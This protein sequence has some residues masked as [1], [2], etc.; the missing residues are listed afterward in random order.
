MENV[1]T[2]LKRE[3]PKK[4]RDPSMFTLPGTIGDRMVSHA[5]LDRG[6]SISAVSYNV[7]QDLK[8]N[9]LQKTTICIQLAKYISPPGIIEV[10]VK[11]V[12]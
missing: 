1:S 2:L 10:L 11:V 8:L 7:F 4:C 9:N 6:A 3:V 5:M 12:N